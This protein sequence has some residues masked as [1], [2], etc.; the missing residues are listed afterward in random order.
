MYGHK[1]R[2][3]GKCIDFSTYFNENGNNTS[4]H[5]PEANIILY[6]MMYV[7]LYKYRVKSIDFSTMFQ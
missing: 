6:H 5:P 1:D 4:I 2:I 3:L 7:I